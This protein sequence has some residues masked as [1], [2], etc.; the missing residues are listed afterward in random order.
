MQHDNN[1]TTK[2]RNLANHPFGLEN[3]EYYIRAWKIL[4][5][6]NGNKLTIDIVNFK[7]TYRR[8]NYAFGNGG[9]AT[10]VFEYFCNER[11]WVL[12]DSKWSGL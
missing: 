10:V 5:V 11:K 6:L 12:V 8:N 3:G 9:G 7:I 2:N 4:P 1:E